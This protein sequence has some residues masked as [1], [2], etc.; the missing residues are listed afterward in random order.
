MIHTYLRRVRPAALFGA[1]EKDPFK[2]LQT[3]Q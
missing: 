3:P 2:G 1:T